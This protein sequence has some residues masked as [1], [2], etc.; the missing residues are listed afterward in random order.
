VL[1][2]LARA[3]AAFTPPEVHRLVGAHS[4]DGVRKA[5]VALTAQGIVVG[6]RSGQAVRY[7]LNRHHLATPYIVGLAGLR[8]ELLT[9]LTRRIEA[10]ESPCLYSALFGSAARNDMLLD[11]DIDLF[12]VR[13]DVIDPDDTRW[14]GQIDLLEADAAR[15]T[16]NDVRTLHYSEAELRTGLHAGDRVLRDVREEGIRLTGPASLLRRVGATT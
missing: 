3:E 9:R 13:F 1:T 10:W 4:V 7:E 14:L 16:G 5:L 2:V 6:Q 12:I 8:D 15:W 11:S